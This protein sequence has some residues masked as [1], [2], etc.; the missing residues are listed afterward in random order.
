[1][2]ALTD[3]RPRGREQLRHE[4]I[5]MRKAIGVFLTVALII[6]LVGMWMRSA[7]VATESVTAAAAQPPAGAISPFE[8]M[9]KS[10]KALPNQYYPD[11]F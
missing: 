10:R 6:A 4:V 11:P 2:T 1:V 8:L 7:P 9:S 5:M 3:D